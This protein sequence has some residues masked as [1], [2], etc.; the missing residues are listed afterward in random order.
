[1]FSECTEFNSPL[2]NWD[3]SK[4]TNTN[5]MF[6]SARSFNQPLNNWNVSTNINMGGMFKLASSFKQDISGWCVSN[7]P[8][9]PKDFALGI[10]PHHLPQWG[11]CPNG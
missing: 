8:E 6:Y 2:N 5:D 7:I 11:T 3:V 1:M 4:T 10:E 9:A